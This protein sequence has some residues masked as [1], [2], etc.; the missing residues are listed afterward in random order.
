M[1]KSVKRLNI[2]DIWQWLRWMFQSYK[3]GISKANKL[4]GW[5]YSVIFTLSVFTPVLTTDNI[6]PS[7][8]FYSRKL[9]SYGNEHLY[10][11]IIANPFIFFISLFIGIITYRYYFYRSIA[12]K[13]P[14]S[15]Q[16]Y[17]RHS[18]IELAEQTK[19]FG[20]WMTLIDVISLVIPE[21]LY[22]NRI[23]LKNTQENNEEFQSLVDNLLFTLQKN[24]SITS[25]HFYGSIFNDIDLSIYNSTGVHPT[26]KLQLL[27]EDFEVSALQLILSDDKYSKNT[28]FGQSLAD[29]FRSQGYGIFYYNTFVDDQSHRKVEKY[30]VHHF[31]DR[32]KQIYYI[33]ELN[34][35]LRSYISEGNILIPLTDRNSRN[36]Q[37]VLFGFLNV[38]IDTYIFSDHILSKF[39]LP[40]LVG[41]SEAIGYY[42]SEMRR[43]L[44]KGSDI[45]KPADEL[46]KE[47]D[48]L[49]MLRD[50]YTR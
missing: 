11:V 35:N 16:K 49:E 48:F 4:F 24:S 18:F 31:T 27:T 20:R 15:L 9:F 7:L 14:D 6:S 2:L 38:Y 19:L 32:M 34:V 46:S 8:G 36:G 29:N 10:L 28:D 50:C 21:I 22:E 42:L 12:Q 45:L 3:I 37:Y 25:K 39:V 23:K 33:D 41:Y 1:N 5:T 17:S 43:N 30:K 40:N 47:F 44:E 26:I 13:S